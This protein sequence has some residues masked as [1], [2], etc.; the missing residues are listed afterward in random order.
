MTNEEMQKRIEASPALRELRDDLSSELSNNIDG[1]PQIAIILIIA[2]ISLIVQIMTYCKNKPKADVRQDVRNIRSLRPRQV[3]RL[4]RRANKLWGDYCEENK[5]PATG[6]NPVL[7]SLYSVAEKGS[8]AA[9]DELLS[10][11]MD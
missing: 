6:S 4:T 5:L 8:D 7:A 9:L 10:I 3:M 2:M 1:Q 11:A